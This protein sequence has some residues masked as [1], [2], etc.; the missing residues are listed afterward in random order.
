MTE[1]YSGTA[2]V[3]R[4]ID[5]RQ[6]EVAVVSLDQILEHAQSMARIRPPR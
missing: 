1:N 5:V 4:P 6:Q 2:N 3:A